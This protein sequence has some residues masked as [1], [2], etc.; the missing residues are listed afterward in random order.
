[1]LPDPPTLLCLGQRPQLLIFL[2]SDLRCNYCCFCLVENQFLWFSISDI[3]DIVYML[4]DL[5]DWRKKACDVAA[6]I[7][8]GSHGFQ[9]FSVVLNGS[10]WFS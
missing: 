9:W 2:P 8:T 5:Q 6:Y 3:N 10:L 1:M 7:L 4:M